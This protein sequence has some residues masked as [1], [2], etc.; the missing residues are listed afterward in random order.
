LRGGARG[1]ILH[2][3]VRG[4]PPA[5]A[6]PP[7]RASQTVTDA[8]TPAIRYVL[9]I[10]EPHTHLMH[11]EMEVDGVSGPVELVMPSWTPGSYLM[12]EFPRNVMVLMAGD[13]SGPVPAEKTDKNTWRVEAPAGGR[14]AVRYVVAADE[15]SVRTSHVDAGHASVNGASAFLLVRG[16]EHQPLQLTVAAPAGWRTTTSLREAEPGVFVAADYDELVDSPLEIGTHGLWEWEVEGKKHR[17]AIWGRGNFD[18][19]RLAEDTTRIVRAEKALFGTLPYDD[20]TFILHLT[21]GGSGGLEHRASTL[22]HA[23]RWSFRG[24][25]YESFLGLTAHELFHAWNGKRI[26]PAA[27]GPFDY[28]REAYTRE[29]WVVEGITSYYTD[30]VLRRAGIVTPQRYLE[31]LAETIT[32]MYGV[33]GRMVQPLEDAS[34]DTWIKFYRPDANT[35]N[36]TVSYYQKGALVALL[37]DLKVR[38]ATANARS[39]DDVMRLLWERF[40]ATDLGFPPGE[41]ERI[42]AEVAGEDLQA[43]FD[44]TLRGR[45]E[46]DYATH[47]AAAGLQLVQAQV[48]IPPGAQAAGAPAGEPGAQPR[49]P[50]DVRIGV[51]MKFEGGKAIVGNVLAD[52]PAWRAGLNAG[53]ELVALDGLRVGL[54]SL[55]ARLADRKPGDRVS[56]TV[57]RRDELVTVPF[58]IELTPPQRWD[59]RPV[60]QPTP[61]QVALRDDWLRAVVGGAV[62]GASASAAG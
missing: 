16:R 49:P 41:V 40:G 35:P 56:L 61:E 51:Q 12:R 53:D 34:F 27:L 50:M 13:A 62:A 4:A 21:P 17:W 60:L 36:A 59:I 55:P 54:E 48:P 8:A 38:H 5:R 22:L 7:N 1:T 25:A 33:P 24:P 11:V 57:F 19:Q 32:R 37:L 42:A 58:E 9:R 14:L 46:L 10:P 39:L 47:L 2:G 20:Y 18:P 44:A 3:P 29:L 23:D 6:G 28:T 30:L 52:T 15:L 26:R 31:R 45:G 43:F